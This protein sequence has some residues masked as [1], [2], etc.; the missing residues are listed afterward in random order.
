M[1]RILGYKD[2]INTYY[3]SRYIRLRMTFTKLFQ[4]GRQMYL[5]SYPGML[6]VHKVEIPS[7]SHIRNTPNRVSSTGAFSAAENA[8]ASTRRVSPGRM[9]P[10]SHSLAVA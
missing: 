9:M 5:C 2:I 8:S 10:S 4:I 1:P 7:Y 6:L 3:I